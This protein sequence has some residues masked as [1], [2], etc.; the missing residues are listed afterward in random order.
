MTSYWSMWRIWKWL[1]SAHK[2]HWPIFQ[3]IMTL[4]SAMFQKD[5]LSVSVILCNCVAELSLLSFTNQNFNWKILSESVS[6]NRTLPV[7]ICLVIFQCFWNTFKVCD[8]CTAISFHRSFPVL[9]ICTG[10]TGHLDD[11]LQKHETLDEYVQITQ[12]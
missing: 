6:L 7:S 3:F 12:T 11:C 9:F 1:I 5:L 4:H 8:I 10:F 2:L